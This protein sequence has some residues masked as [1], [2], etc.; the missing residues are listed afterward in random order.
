[1]SRRE[2]LL[3]TLEQRDKEK[4]ESRSV[5]AGPATNA[6][7]TAGAGAG[8]RLVKTESGLKVHGAV[9]NEPAG[10]STSA[11]LNVKSE[12][13]TAVKKEPPSSKGWIEYPV[14]L[15]STKSS[16]MVIEKDAVR[17]LPLRLEYEEAEELLADYKPDTGSG[18][19]FQ[20]DREKLKEIQL[21]ARMEARKAKRAAPKY[22]MKNSTA[23]SW[24]GE[25]RAP[26]DATGASATLIFL[27]Q[28]Q[29]FQCYE[30]E[31]DV[32]F[33][34]RTKRRDVCA[35]A[36]DYDEASKRKAPFF[37]GTDGNRAQL[38]GWIA[39]TH[40]RV[41]K[42]QL[43]T[44]EPGEFLVK[45]E[46]IVVEEEEVATKKKKRGGFGAEGE[47]FGGLAEEEGVDATILYTEGTQEDEGN[48]DYEKLMETVLDEDSA[49]S[50]SEVAE[51]DDIAKQFYHE[52]QGFIEDKRRPGFYTSVEDVDDEDE[53]DENNEVVSNPD[54][55]DEMADEN[56]GSNSED[57]DLL[58]GGD[59]GSEG[60]ANLAVKIKIKTESST[61]TK[62]EVPSNKTAAS[63]RKTD[64]VDADLE[65]TAQASKKTRVRSNFER[66][67]Q[68]IEL[69]TTFLKHFARND[70]T[71]VEIINL[72]KKKLKW[73]T[74]DDG[75][76][77]QWFEQL[78]ID[79]TE[80]RQLATGKWAKKGN[81][82][83]YFLKGEKK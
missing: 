73:F 59:N 33:T 39:Q 65:A 44:V 55:D 24:I 56:F 6:Y 38:P 32:K 1:M 63:K 30:V 77:K 54:L 17:N 41:R 35:S 16:I 46:D 83:I 47:D 76:T 22:I 67:D 2:K 26:L 45:N 18:S 29:D 28:G 70:F 34:R 66:S 52:K 57:D 8:A 11:G 71:M 43:S 4:S 62:H 36:E 68:G 60:T 19:V 20:N 25:K 69:K 5:P 81:D 50:E 23:H 74:I 51:E 48:E 3:K 10:S 72:L 61:T 64:D 31:S 21:Q 7:D 58:Q 53:D 42:S 13:S 82:Y 79:F 14:Y 15:Y 27:K 49:S 40:E 80:K 37:I 75:D 9:K 12:P 78:V